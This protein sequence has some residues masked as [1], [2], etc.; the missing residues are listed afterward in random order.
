MHVRICTTYGR[1]LGFA[2][3]LIEMILFE[4]FIICI[5]DSAYLTRKHAV[6][7]FNLCWHV[8]QKYVAMI[9]DYFTCFVQPHF[10]KSHF[11][12]CVVF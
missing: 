8:I 4:T 12:I 2:S 1:F 6:L 10:Y 3:I 11:V 9:R 7:R 5:I